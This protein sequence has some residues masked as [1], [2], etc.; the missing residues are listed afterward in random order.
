MVS[1]QPSSI[2][3]E[4]PLVSNRTM[5][6]M[7]QGIVQS[8]MLDEFLLRSQPKKA[9]LPKKSLHRGQEA[10]RVSALLGL[11]P[12][13]FTSDLPGSMVTAFLRGVALKNVVNAAA[14]STSKMPGAAASNV[15]L[16][17]LLPGQED[18]AIR[19][20]TAM[21]AALALKR[22]NL[23]KVVIVFADAQELKPS[24]WREIL[25]TAARE[26]LPMLFVALPASLNQAK[27]GKANGKSRKQAKT[28]AL[29]ARSTSCG[30]PGIPV[31]AG[32]AVALYRVA[33]ESVGRARA[34]G[35]PALMECV[36]LVIEEN[37]ETK[38][39]KR[40]KKTPFDPA[41]AIGRT[42]VSK[43]V[44]S[45]QWLD[46]VTSAFQARLDAL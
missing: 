45:Q 16:A 11:E 28:F 32:D 27:A 21:G 18:S 33:Q 17:G 38:K 29:S 44:C 34:G 6:Q 26:E 42:L 14:S 4:S 5:Q 36:H 22:L 41:A 15:V 20:R 25:N 10:C 23:H 31:G 39:T 2:P 3:A 43:K 40:T 12:E 37:S 35:G 30:V 1:D 9:K 24:A 46:G 19:L 13:D 8:H 7:F